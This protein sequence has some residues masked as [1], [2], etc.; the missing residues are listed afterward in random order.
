VAIPRSP[1]SFYAEV[2]TAVPELDERLTIFRDEYRRHRAATRRPV[3]VLDVGCGRNP[4]LADHIEDGDTW[5][6]CDIAPP[7]RADLNFLVAD[8]NEQALSEVVGARKF[9]VIF[10]GEVIEHVFSPDALLDDLHAVLNDRGLLVLSTPN[11]AYW[12]NRLLL[13]AGISPLFLENSSTKK[14][15][16]RFRWLGQGNETQGHLRLFTYDAML[17]LLDYRRFRFERSY[18]VPVWPLPIDR[19]ICRFSRRLAPDLVYVARPVSGLSEQDSVRST[20][21]T[22]HVR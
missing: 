8:L 2:E 1:V 3:S 11:L 5:T 10:C 22:R 19:L 7:A 9:D 6:G 16:R 15:G 21:P 17:E 18:A 14:L 20:L 13:F 4:V 12:V